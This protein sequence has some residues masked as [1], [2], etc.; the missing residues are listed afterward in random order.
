MR[1]GITQRVDVV[2]GE[3]RDALDRAWP[4]LLATLGHFAFPLPNVPGTAERW[5]T[6]AGLE[7]V[8]LSGG[9]DLAGTP[10]ATNVS[11]ERDRFE[12]ELIELCRKRNLPVLGVCRGMQRLLTHFGIPLEPVAEHVGKPHAL[13]LKGWPGGAGK[14]IVN[15]FHQFGFPRASLTPE[16]TALA[17][18]SDGTVEA[19]RHQSLPFWAVMWHPE[20][21]PELEANRILLS[22]LFSA[23]SRRA[24]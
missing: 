4:E 15:S 17:L 9:N 3:R 24:A 5:L 19:V 13:T 23:S 21:P 16:W 11:V 2:N 22:T 20:R 12:I 8:V 1:I 14:L 18:A 10:K 6:E 7:A